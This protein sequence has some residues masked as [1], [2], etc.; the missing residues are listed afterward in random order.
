M[1]VVMREG[2]LQPSGSVE[3]SLRS[4]ARG[5]H[6]SDQSEGSSEVCVLMDTN[7]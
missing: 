5:A 6:Y 7:M 3:E 1:V 2:L 4:F